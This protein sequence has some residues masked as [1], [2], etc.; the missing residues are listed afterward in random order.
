MASGLKAAACL[1]NHFERLGLPRRFALDPAELERNYL[2]RSREVHPDHAGNDRASLEASAALNE[3]YA[4]LR[5]PFRRADY[6]LTL[7]G[8]P[9]AAEQKQAA[10]EFL[11]EMLDLRMRI[12]EVKHA[13]E[14]SERVTLERDLT[15]RR[16][17]LLGEAGGLFEKLA[18]LPPDDAA[19]PGLLV[20]IRQTLNATK[21][22]QG[23]LR[24]LDEE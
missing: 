23:L 14:S 5:D 8:G 22:I 17:A 20:R 15:L 19:R 1:M 13:A 18:P 21:Y 24:D 3:A 10:P 7:E 11:E 16:E 6:L 2:V 9:T 4:I 12:E